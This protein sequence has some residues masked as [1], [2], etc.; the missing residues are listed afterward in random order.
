MSH[1]LNPAELAHL[2]DDEIEDPF[3]C[4][5]DN[6]D[7]NFKVDSTEYLKITPYVRSAFILLS[8][9]KILAVY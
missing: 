4:G 2:N 1:L 6:D 9:S 7:Y 8:V 5:N 3:L